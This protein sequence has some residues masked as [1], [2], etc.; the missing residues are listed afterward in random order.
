MR[1][2]EGRMRCG[3]YRGGGDRAT[4]GGMRCRPYNYFRYGGGA[5][6]RVAAMA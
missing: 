6:T 4:E 2:T 5:A 3:H 1:A